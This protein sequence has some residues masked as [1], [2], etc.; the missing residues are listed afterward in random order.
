MSQR[1]SPP[2]SPRAKAISWLIILIYSSSPGVGRYTEMVMTE[3]RGSYIKTECGR[4]I[5]DLTCGSQS[6]LLSGVER[7]E[8]RFWSFFENG[9]PDNCIH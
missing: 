7:H 8:L 9:P 4:T 2:L 1:A 6:L 5:L 3:G